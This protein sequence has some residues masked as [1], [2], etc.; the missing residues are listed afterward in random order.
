MIGE[1]SRLYGYQ[2]LTLTR[3]LLSLRE[4]FKQIKGAVSLR[5]GCKAVKRKQW[6]GRRARGTELPLVNAKPFGKLVRF[7]LLT[8]A[9]LDGGDPERLT[10]TLTFDRTLLSHWHPTGE[11]LVGWPLGNPKEGHYEL[12]LDA[13]LRLHVLDIQRQPVPLVLVERA[14]I[15]EVVLT[16][17]QVELDELVEQVSRVQQSLKVQRGLFDRHQPHLFVGA[18][19]LQQVE[20]SFFV[21]NRDLERLRAELL[22]WRDRLSGLDA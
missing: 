20:D 12:V 18:H 17:W 14:A 1:F 4:Q 15:P 7:H 10:G 3:Q 21:L 8:P 19:W 6:F 2:Q 9:P 5:L 13:E 16:P 11:T 22:Q